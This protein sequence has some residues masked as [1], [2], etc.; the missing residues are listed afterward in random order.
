MSTLPPC[1][2]HDKEVEHLRMYA[3]EL[4]DSIILGSKI[5]RIS[6]AIQGERFDT[7][8]GDLLSQTLHDIALNPHVLSDELRFDKRMSPI[9]DPI[10]FIHLERM[11]RLSEAGAIQALARDI[12]GGRLFPN[13]RHLRLS[14]RAQSQLLS[15]LYDHHDD[16]KYKVYLRAFATIADVKELCTD[17]DLRALDSLKL[18]H[19]M[20]ELRTVWPNL[21]VHHIHHALDDIPYTM[22]GI[23]H[24]AIYDMASWPFCKEPWTLDYEPNEVDVNLDPDIDELEDDMAEM[25]LFERAIAMHSG[26]ANT[27]DLR[28]ATGGTAIFDEEKKARER[29]KRLKAFEKFKK[30]EAKAAA[31]AR[32][33]NTYTPW[34]L[35]I[36]R[37]I[38]QDHARGPRDPPTRRKFTLPKL[39]NG[40]SLG[41]LGIAR[42]AMMASLRAGLSGGPLHS[43]TLE[44]EQ[45]DM[46]VN[47]RIRFQYGPPGRCQGCG[48][49]W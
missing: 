4:A 49:S 26:T 21:T 8:N 35:N 34:F 3:P 23:I 32:L 18:R 40:P 22:S 10:A 47:E 43:L 14:W 7:C 37:T 25:V 42:R 45:L 20:D 6:S 33:V 30:E 36:A 39:P 46:W 24:D 29:P 2:N 28:Q 9:I 17:Y 11:P 16:G 41:N 13:A 5:E 44:Q 31:Q 48:K 1:F 38:L 12:P 15:M 27:V 19:G